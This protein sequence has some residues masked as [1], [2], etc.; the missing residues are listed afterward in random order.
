MPSG[1]RRTLENDQ[2]LSEACK[3]GLLRDDSVIVD[4]GERIRAIDFPRYRSIQKDAWVRSRR[5]WIA[6]IPIAILSAVVWLKYDPVD[7][8]YAWPIVIAS[9][10]LTAGAI[11][12]YAFAGQRKLGYWPWC[13]RFFNTAIPMGFLLPFGMV[14]LILGANCLLDKSPVTEHS[15]VVID[16]KES[17]TTRR[18]RK[19]D[20]Y[21]FHLSSWRADLKHIVLPV[22]ASR[23]RKFSIGDPI[24]TKT[25][26]GLLGIEYFVR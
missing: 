13:K 23:Y 12:A 8:R 1:E 17:H 4:N 21:Y 18:G 14:S 10:P 24:T 20:H 22:S 26:A 3:T 25:R 6:L 19:R 9:L 15:A 16:K 2:Q 7:D 11:W 5:V